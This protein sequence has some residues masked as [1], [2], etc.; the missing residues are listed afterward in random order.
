VAAIQKLGVRTIGEID[1]VPTPDRLKWTF[2][3]CRKYGFDG[4]YIG[5]VENIFK[6][7]KPTAAGELCGGLIKEYTTLKR[8]VKP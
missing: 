7:G 8:R 2:E 5:V 6:E 3:Q 1:V 4:V